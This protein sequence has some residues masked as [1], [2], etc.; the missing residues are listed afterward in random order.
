MHV[1][2]GQRKHG[3]VAQLRNNLPNYYTRIGPSKYKPQIMA[4]SFG[5]VVMF[6]NLC[7]LFSLPY[8]L[9]M[10]DLWDILTYDSKAKFGRIFF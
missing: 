3:H 7:C 9:V 5:K 8:T 1:R 6:V 4:L 10:D 2:G